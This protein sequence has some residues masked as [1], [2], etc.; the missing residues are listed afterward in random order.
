MLVL[1]LLKKTLAAEIPGYPCCSFRGSMLS[2]NANTGSINWKT[3][4]TP[5]NFSGVSPWGS[6]PSIDTQMGAVFIGTG[7]NYKVSAAVEACIQTG[8][9]TCNPSDNYVDSIVALNIYDGSVIWS[10]GF[11]YPESIDVWTLAC[12]FNP[13]NNPNCPPDAGIDTDFAQ[14]PFMFTGREGHMLRPLLGVGQKNGFFHVL[15]RAT[16]DIIRTTVAGPD[17]LSGGL[18]WGSAYDGTRI[19]VASANT[20][21]VNNT[22]INGQVVQTGVWLAID[23][24]TG[25]ILWQTPVPLHNASLPA[26]I[27]NP[28]AYSPVT[29]ANDVVYV[30]SSTIG[31]PNFFALSAIDGR[32]LWSFSPGGAGVGG[33]TV[34]DGIIYWG[35]GYARGAPQLGSNVFYAFSI[36]QEHVCCPPQYSFEEYEL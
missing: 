7:N 31:G 11:S 22:L 13:F 27:Q 5:T 12:V 14:A 36:P 23:P 26:A 32:I 18:Q 28:Y 1:H 2:L 35:N 17:G 24:N 29:V 9:L 3:Y 6:S 21:S 33:A 19:Y 10:T 25:S 8:S 15:D 30:G 4:L 20:N 34:A 16:G